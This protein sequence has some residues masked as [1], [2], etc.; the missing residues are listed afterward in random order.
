MRT[1]PLAYRIG[2]PE[3]AEFEHVDDEVWQ[4]E[5][6]GAIGSMHGGGE[7]GGGETGGGETGGGETGEVLDELLADVLF[8]T[9]LLTPAPEP[10]VVLPND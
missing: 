10:M 3:H 5:Q 8:E 4:Q 1:S 2:L 7:T 6:D 9:S